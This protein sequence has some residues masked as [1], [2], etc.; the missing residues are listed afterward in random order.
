MESSNLF[1][2]K[3]SFIKGE[4]GEENLLT[5]YKRSYFPNFSLLLS[6]NMYLLHLYN[7]LR[8]LK[9]FFFAICNKI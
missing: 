7:P 8:T 2:T 9:K 3:Y 5:D 6:A 1:L 4:D